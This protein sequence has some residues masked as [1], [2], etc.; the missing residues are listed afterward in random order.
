M[1]VSPFSNNM[2]FWSQNDV[3][4]FPPPHALSTPT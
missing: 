2:E 4:A 3:L 1:T